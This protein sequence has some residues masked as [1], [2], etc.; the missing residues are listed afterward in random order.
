MPKTRLSWID[1]WNSKFQYLWKLNPTGSVSKF[2]STSFQT[3]LDNQIFIFALIV[4]RALILWVIYKLQRHLV[5]G[6]L[7]AGSSRMS[8]ST[9][10]DDD[11]LNQIFEWR[12]FFVD[13]PPPPR[14]HHCEEVQRM[15]KKRG[16]KKIPSKLE[17]G[18]WIKIARLS[19]AYT[20]VQ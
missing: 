9:R 10:Y 16:G 15:L 2:S 4:N 6:E 1:L 12:K 19:Y 18:L 11:N 7:A 8:V 5:G 14:L 13:N 20:W 17:V 3:R